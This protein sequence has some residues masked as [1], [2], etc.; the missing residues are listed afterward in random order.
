MFLLDLVR[1]ENGMGLRILV[2]ESDAKMR[3]TLCRQLKKIWGVVDVVEAPSFDE[4]VGVFNSHK[5]IFDGIVL[6]SPKVLEFVRCLKYTGIIVASSSGDVAND[7]MI[8]CG[9]NGKACAVDSWVGKETALG[10]LMSLL[11]RKK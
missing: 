6:D 5:G 11:H 9:A 7:V 4:A 8:E 3:A 10:V 2:V 1:K